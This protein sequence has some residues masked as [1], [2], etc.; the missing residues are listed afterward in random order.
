M[1][2][3]VA[4]QSIDDHFLSKS[5]LRLVFTGHKHLHP[6]LADDADDAAQALEDHAAAVDA[7]KAAIENAANWLTDR[8]NDASNLVGNTVETLKEGDEVRQGTVIGYV[9]NSGNAGE[10]NFHLHF[11]IA[12]VQ[13]PKRFWTGEY[14]DPFPYL[15]NGISPGSE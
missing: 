8:W 12:R 10:G 4:R 3:D 2:F 11:S 14:I 7:M 5:D 15:K 6:G 9:G 1:P 13:D